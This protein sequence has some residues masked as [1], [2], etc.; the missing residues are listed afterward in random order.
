MQDYDKTRL[1]LLLMLL[2]CDQ[3]MNVYGTVGQHSFTRHSLSRMSL[4]EHE[5]ERNIIQS[6]KAKTVPELRS[7]E[8][9]LSCSIE[10]IQR[11]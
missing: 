8:S 2:T 11:G 10:S 3:R 7:L 4:L 1:E 6:Q 5:V 9:L